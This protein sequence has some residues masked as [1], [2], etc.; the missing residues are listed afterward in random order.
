MR[1]YYSMLSLC[2]I[3]CSVHKDFWQFDRG[4]YG[5]GFP[6][7]GV[8]CFAAQINKLLIHYGCSS[9]LGIHMQV[10][11][12]IFIIDGRV[13]TQILAAPFKKYGKWV[14][15]GWLKSLWEKLDMFNFR[16]EILKLPLAIPREGDCW[17]M[18]AFIELDF[19]MDEL[20]Q[21][22]RYRCHQQVI[23]KL[24]VFGASGCAL[25]KR[26]LERCPPDK[27]WLTLLFTQERPPT[28]DRRLWHQ[29][30]HAI[31]LRGRA[32][33]RLGRFMAKG[34]KIWP[35]RY[36]QENSR[37]Y[38]LKGA[39]MDVHGLPTGAGQS[40]RPNRW[41]SIKTDWARC[42]EGAICTVCDLPGNKKAIISYL[43]GPPRD[44]APSTF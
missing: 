26:Y 39:T 3:Q 11:M 25:D 37:L 17:I 41:C 32:E 44:T 19:F 21:L 15:D 24:D 40:R 7:S 43:D 31:E 28:C 14:T 12:E 23:F 27:V 6:H 5:V 18:T 34:H 42:D 35:W 38:H 8:E 29:A 33:R 1:S 10:S 9:G 22:N 16:V 20:I 13:L 30:L 36:D 2:G 4:F